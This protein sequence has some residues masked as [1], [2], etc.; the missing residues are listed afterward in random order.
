MEASQGLEYQV[1]LCL[2]TDVSTEGMLRTL[3]GGEAAVVGKARA[4]SGLIL[5]ESPFRG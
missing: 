5:E 2:G 1:G 3:S 4:T